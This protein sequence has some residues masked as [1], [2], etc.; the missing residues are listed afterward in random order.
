M[1][2]P[3]VFI[4]STVYDFEDLRSATQ[5]FLEE[6]G[7]DVQ[8]SET[9][10]FNQDISM[11]SYDSCLQ[12]IESCQY[13]ILFIGARVGGRVKD[14]G[15]ISITRAEYRKAYECFQR[16]RLHLV[17]FVRQSIWDIKEDRKAIAAAIQEHFKNTDPTAAAKLMATPSRLVEDAAHTFDFIDEVRR[18]TVTRPT[19]R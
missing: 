4:S 12:V 3:R 9:P 10:T 7:F 14:M 5:F 6:H 19:F 13:F 16:G 17:N 11:H 15:N 2:R 18:A 1:S 8:L